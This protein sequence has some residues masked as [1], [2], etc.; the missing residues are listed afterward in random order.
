MLVT[1]S[2]HA[3]SCGYDISC[4]ATLKLTTAVS[5]M[6]KQLDERSGIQAIGLEELKANLNKSLASTAAIF[7]HLEKLSAN[8]LRHDERLKALEKSM[9]G[10]WVFFCLT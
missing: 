7:T 6:K 9:Q 8:L 5:E 1:A 4:H 10:E 2:D 3:I